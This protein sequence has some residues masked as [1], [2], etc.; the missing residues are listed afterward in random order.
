[1]RKRYWVLPTLLGV[2]F[3]VSGI[4]GYNQYRQKQQYRIYL[5]NQYQKSF[6][7][8][9]GNVDNLESRLSK[10]MVSSSPSQNIILLSEIWRQ[11]NSAQ[12]NLGQ[13]PVSHVAL[14]NTSK[15]INQLGDFS[16]YLAKK[17]ADGKPL[18]REDM[19]KLKKLHSNCVVLNTELQGMENQVSSGTIQWGEIPREGTDHF[20]EASK[21]IANEQFTRLQKTA[22]DYPVLIYDGPFSES[23][24]KAEPK[25]LGSEDVTEEQAK[26]IALK[27]LGTDYVQNI[28][29]SSEGNGKIKTWG[30]DGQT[31]KGGK[32]FSIHITKKGGQVLWMV[33]NSGNLTRKLSVDQC[34]QKAQIFLKEKG[35]PNMI[36]TY[37]QYYDGVA[38]INFAGRLGETIVYPDLIKVKVSMED[39][40]IIG[41]DA[42]NYIM[43]HTQRTV[44]EPKLSKEEAQSLVSGNLKVTSVR[45][46]IIPTETRGEKLC[47]EFKGTFG[48]DN[49]IVY[50]NA[51]TGKEESILKIIDTENGSLVL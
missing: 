38:V 12:D 23:L 18:T 16:Y 3:I 33:E 48:G 13:L 39:G 15:F 22:N 2:L 49:F 36:A 29:K 35:Y 41:Y 25:G 24:N 26:Q 34:T 40:R 45:L 4:W 32:A 7:E 5:Q 46:A 21:N 27:F 43:S 30:F 14:L 42:Q 1:M 17:A 50:I 47:Y 9:V 31:K 37:T 20:G 6:F 8:L 19:E 11:S 51:D 28:A 10:L 44:R